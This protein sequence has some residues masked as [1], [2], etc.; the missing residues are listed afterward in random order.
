MMKLF[1]EYKEKEKVTVINDE[2]V[3][4]LEVAIK[5]NF[6]RKKKPENITFCS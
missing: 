1:V 6:N 3:N 2:M 5:Q 4:R